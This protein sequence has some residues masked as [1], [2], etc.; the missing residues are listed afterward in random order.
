MKK[1]VTI[2]N[3][4]NLLDI[5]IQTKG[6]PQAA[7][8]LAIENNLS[9][10]ELLT[11]T[12]ELIIPQSETNNKDIQAYYNRKLIK[13]ATYQETQ[14]YSAIGIGLMGIEYTFKVR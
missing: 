1:K 9:L 8:D 4:Q 12:E 11:P 10:T 13:P 5:A 6:N 2:L 7:F 14:T 3:N